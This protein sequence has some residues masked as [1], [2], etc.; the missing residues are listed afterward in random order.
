M[1]SESDGPM[2]GQVVACLMSVVGVDGRGEALT[3]YRPS[4]S[5][6]FITALLSFDAFK[7][8]VCCASTPHPRS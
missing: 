4:L 2:Y 7:K 3:I 6:V 8:W 5:V 1:F